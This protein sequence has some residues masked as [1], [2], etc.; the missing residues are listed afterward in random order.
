MPLRLCQALTIGV[1]GESNTPLLYVQN[2]ININSESK[3]TENEFYIAERF[4]TDDKIL[5]QNFEDRLYGVRKSNIY[6]YGAICPEYD[7]NS[8]YLNTLFCGDEY[9]V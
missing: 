3:P 8:P 6:R 9:I 7:I 4:L 2:K 1:D 5:E